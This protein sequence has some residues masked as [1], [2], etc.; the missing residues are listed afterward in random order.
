[1]KYSFGGQNEKDTQNGCLQ[2]AV[3]CKGGKSAGGKGS[4]RN[5]PCAKPL[6]GVRRQQADNVANID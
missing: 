6:G 5:P 3:L 1:M 4:D 2:Q